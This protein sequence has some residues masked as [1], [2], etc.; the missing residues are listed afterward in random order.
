MRLLFSDQGDQVLDNDGPAL[1][2][3]G[4]GPS[5]V[6]DGDGLHVNSPA[7]VCDDTGPINEPGDAA[8]SSKSM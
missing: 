3:D 7:P 2:L 8:K 6:L 1:I 5:Q 4:D